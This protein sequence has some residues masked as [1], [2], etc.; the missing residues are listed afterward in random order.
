M[1]SLSD[2]VRRLQ[3][4]LAE[5]LRGE[6]LR[7]SAELNV[8]F[9]SGHWRI[10]EPSDTALPAGCIHRL[11]VEVGASVPPETPARPFAETPRATEDAASLIA[12]LSEAFGPPGFDSSARASV[13]RE[14]LETLSA[15][16]ARA[17]IA[18]AGRPQSAPEAPATIRQAA[19]LIGRLLE[20]GPAG[21]ERGR[22]LLTTLFK[23][24]EPAALLALIL[25][26]W[27]TQDDWIA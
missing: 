14:S 20:R 21:L 23:T 7:V 17:A 9:E 8:V 11:T 27:K 13:L 6:P 26:T 12:A 5:V 18:A 4:D 1:S 2:A 24:R 3:S 15:E 10:A 16:E 19:H 25:A 22:D